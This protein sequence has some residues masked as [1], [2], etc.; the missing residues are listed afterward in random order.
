[1][2]LASSMPSISEGDTHNAFRKGESIRCNARLLPYRLDG[3]SNQ[4]HDGLQRKVRVS[5]SRWLRQPE[6]QASGERATTT[7]L[8]PR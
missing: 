3:F 2:P 6:T 8:R 7:G 1:M 5:P 4:A